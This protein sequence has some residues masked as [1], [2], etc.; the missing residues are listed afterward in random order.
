[1]PRR[2]HDDDDYEDDRPRK[3]R[4]S[5]DDDYDER[6]PAESNT[7]LILLIVGGVF[8]L[9]FL[10][11]G[12]IGFMMYRGLQQGI[13][14]VGASAQNMQ[15]SNNLKQ[16]GLGMH[17]QS[18]TNNGLAAPFTVDKTGTVRPGLSFR[19]GLLPYIEQD[20]LYRRFDMTKAWDAPENKTLGQVVVPQYT[21]P[22]APQSSDTPFRVF[23]GG[24]ALFETDGKLL[25]L[26]SVSDGLSNT[27]M[28]VA[29]TD[30]VPWSKPQE[31]P[32]SKTTPLPKLQVTANGK[33]LVLMAD[34]ST[35]YVSP[36]ISE[37]VLRQA[38]EKA[39]GNVINWPGE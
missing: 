26:S 20:A 22:N 15:Q 30:S 35:R 36:T 32:Y 24:G 25:K 28:V 7:K 37:L 17:S 10:V 34:G 9:F 11:C 21:G 5:R 27:I 39:D 29:G 8:G 38:I 16:I 18:D 19:V 1:M 14:Q 6:P 23:H 31:F 12:G 13:Q 33:Y 3:R 4:R 2:P